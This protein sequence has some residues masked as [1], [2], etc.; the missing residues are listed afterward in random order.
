MD[1]SLNAR[2]FHEGLEKARES[3]RLFVNADKK[4]E[5]FQN[6]AFI[7]FYSTS[8]LTNDFD[9]G[10]IE[11][12]KPKGKGFSMYGS[13]MCVLLTGFIARTQIVQLQE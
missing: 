2:F 4:S 9:L 7:D 1:L 10:H 12:K 6:K 11:V 13:M 5:T 8:N 3:L